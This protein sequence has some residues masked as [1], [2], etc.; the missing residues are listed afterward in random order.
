MESFKTFTPS[1]IHYCVPFVSLLFYAVRLV[2]GRTINQGRVEVYYNGQW[3][4]VCDDGWDLNDAQV[5]CRELNLGQALHAV[6]GS[7]YHQGTGQIWLD[8]VNCAGG[9]SSI[10]SC[11]HSGWGIRNCGHAKEAGVFCSTTGMKPIA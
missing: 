8:N 11:S 3:G 4:T 10:R 2:N 5:V 9:E 7:F 6:R 1:N